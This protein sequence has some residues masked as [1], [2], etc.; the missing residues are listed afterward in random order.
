MEPVDHAVCRLIE[1]AA[2]AQGLP[3]SFLTR[4]IWR[5]SSFR[6][7]VVSP[8]GA[9]GIAQFMPGTA[10]ERGL[11]DPFD[12]EQAIPK[13]AGFLADL[14]RQFGSLKVAAAAYN[15]GPARVANWLHGEGDLPAVTR[16]YMRFVTEGSADTEN[17]AATPMD[18]TDAATAH[19]APQTCLAL[20]A[21]L[22][23]DSDDG[24]G[25]ASAPWGVQLAGNFSKV[26]AL[27]SFERARRRYSRVIA[28]MQ[29]M[30]IGRLLRSR[31]TRRF[32]QI[33]LPAASRG[34]ADAL[35]NRIH[36]VGGN[37]VAL[38]S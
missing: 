22:R 6:A 23:Q 30:I 21:T 12:P 8:A 25:F 17:D 33:R 13:A 29:P 15:A 4:I 31:G 16:S 18:D 7:G 37:C 34:A 20:T 36:A 2:R 26:K 24:P 32:Y 5:E 35:C 10:R 28:D 1:S 11:A 27:A 14:R 38:R 19:D 9:A 3:V